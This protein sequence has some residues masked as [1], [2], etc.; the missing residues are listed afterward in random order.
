[1]EA[2]MDDP[3]T[4]QCAESTSSAGDPRA[5]SRAWHKRL[6]ASFKRLAEDPQLLASIERRG[7]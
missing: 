6:T 7:F 3:K 4:E 5:S 2:V 1:M